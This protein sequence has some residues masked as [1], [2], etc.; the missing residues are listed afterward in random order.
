MLTLSNSIKI[1]K[2]V[3]VIKEEGDFQDCHQQVYD[4]LSIVLATDEHRSLTNYKFRLLFCNKIKNSKGRRTLATIKVLGDKERL[5]C[6]VDILIVIDFFFWTENPEKQE[7][8]LFHELCHLQVDEE[9]KLVST[10]HDLEE[11]YAVVKKY[12]DWNK[13]AKP[14]AEAIKQLDLLEKVEELKTAYS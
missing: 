9:G 10:G 14:I 8:L 12:G 2:A 13:Q 7:P 6:G 5:L 1:H 11:F 3:D 4:V